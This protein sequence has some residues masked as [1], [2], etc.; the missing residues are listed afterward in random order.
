M[1]LRIKLT[2][3][4]LPEFVQVVPSRQL[5]AIDLHWPFERDGLICRFSLQQR[6]CYIFL[7]IIRRPMQL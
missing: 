2:V 6:P 1:Q 7:A 3:V 5:F 4:L